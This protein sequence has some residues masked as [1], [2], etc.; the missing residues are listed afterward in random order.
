MMFTRREK[1]YP[2]AETDGVKDK[3]RSL[4]ND[5]HLLS[6]QDWAVSLVWKRKTEH[7]FLI[8]EGKKDNEYTIFRSDMFLDMRGQPFPEAEEK[9]AKSAINVLWEA[10]QQS[11]GGGGFIRLKE[12]NI[13]ELSRLADACEYQSWGLSLDD[14][15]KLLKRLISEGNKIYSYH[16]IG[17]N[18]SGS[19]STSHSKNHNCVSWCQEIL[20]TE[21][22]FLVGND[23]A[24]VKKP[25]EIVKQ[26][27]LQNKK[28]TE[29]VKPASGNNTNSTPQKK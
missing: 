6:E 25:S 28:Q 22:N 11:S 1:K 14:A 20:K 8:I 26:A 23:W 3:V 4:I 9:T 27:I 15:E 16:I 29:Q 24:F 17:D 5:A 7:A 19:M 12:L 21:L 10:S 13:D 2:D 18:L